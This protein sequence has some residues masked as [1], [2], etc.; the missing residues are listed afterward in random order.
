MPPG[1]G[2]WTVSINGG[3]NPH[4]RQDGKELYFQTP[5][6][7]IMVVDTVVSPTFNAGIPRELSRL[8]AGSRGFAPFPDGRR[9]LVESRAGS[10]RDNP[11]NVVLNWWADLAKAR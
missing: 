3:A 2:R 5:E 1:T 4:W 8:P 10:D 6:S 11:I 9:F 7:R